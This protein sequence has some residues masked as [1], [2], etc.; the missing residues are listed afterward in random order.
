MSKPSAA[1]ADARVRRV[2]S[3]RGLRRGDPVAVNV[4]REYRGQ[5]SFVAFARNEV[6]GEEWVEVRGGRAGESKGRAF[7]PEVIFPVNARRGSRFV[8]PSYVD[9]PQLALEERA[10]RQ[11]R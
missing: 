1:A 8:G 2:E 7:R 4:E 3:W 9:A 11:R 6:T 10:P 5:W